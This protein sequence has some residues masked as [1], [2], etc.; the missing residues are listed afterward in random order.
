MSVE[1]GVK[2]RRHK[3][4]SKYSTFT[5][6]EIGGVIKNIFTVDVEDYYNVSSFE[7][8][9]APSEWHKQKS[10]IVPNT[11]AL[12]KL[13]N[14]FQTKATFFVLGW[15]AEMY[16][17]VVMMIYQNGHEIGCHSFY[18]R[19]IYDLTPDEFRED[20]KRAK[21]VIEDI[22]GK[23]VLGYRAPSFSITNKSQWA[24]EILA[25]LGFKYSS[26]IYPIKHDRYGFSGMPRTAFSVNKDS[27]APIIEVPMSTVRLL[28]RN[29]PVAGGG[30]LRLFPYWFTRRSIISLHR[31]NIPAVVYVH[32][33]EL[34]PDQP[35][36]KCSWKKKW[37]HYTNI[38][39]TERK[40]KSLLSEF[41]FQSMH[42]YL[43]VIRKN[44]LGS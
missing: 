24:W 17:E 23:P 18:H 12:L 29:F 11:I 9:I 33:W 42:D 15:I 41:E 34:D 1:T 25:E 6:D 20:T 14:G 2:S 39:T 26:S 3:E 31:E 32:P 13:L 4:T 36:I 22:I 43:S 10:R 44:S 37:R 7:K 5:G 40:L 19:L 8:I 28:G 38:R 35:R 30:Y 21:S 27:A 16:P